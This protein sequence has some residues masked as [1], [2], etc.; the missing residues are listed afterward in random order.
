MCTYLPA[1]YVH[2]YLPF[3]AGSDSFHPLLAEITHNETVD[4]S[5]T[6]HLLEHNMPTSPEEQSATG[7]R[8]VPTPREDS[9]TH[10][11]PSPER[12]RTEHAV[13]ESCQGQPQESVLTLDDTVKTDAELTALNLSN[14]SICDDSPAL[15]LP[16]PAGMS[17]E[18]KNLQ[19]PG[20]FSDICTEEL[21]SEQGSIFRDK[22]SVSDKILVWF[23]CFHLKAENQ[24]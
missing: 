21:K 11:D 15:D 10:S 19:L 12:L 3:F 1:Y 22:L 6:F 24:F 5:M 20:P 4:P 18:A 2:V 16:Q 14:F 17:A 8:S 7:R 9:E 13:P 23:P